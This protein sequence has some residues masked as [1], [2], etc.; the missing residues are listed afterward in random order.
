M[1]MSGRWHPIWA[2]E[3]FDLG[4][5]HSPLQCVSMRMLNETL[6]LSQR[7]IFWYS[8]RAITRTEPNLWNLEMRKVL[9]FIR[10]CSALFLLFGGNFFCSGHTSRSSTDFALI[11]CHIFWNTIEWKIN[12]KFELTMKAFMWEWRRMCGRNCWKA[13]TVIF[14]LSVNLSDPLNLASETHKSQ[15]ILAQERFKMTCLL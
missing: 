5:F 12:I 8:R 6:L 3:F 9:R 11:C 1:D 14:F 2:T 15:C 13:S 4:F 7:L 10:L